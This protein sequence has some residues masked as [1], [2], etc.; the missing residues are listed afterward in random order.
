[1]DN[2]IFV[3]CNPFVAHQRFLMIFSSCQMKF[4]AV[5]SGDLRAICE[6]GLL[7]VTITI[8]E[9]EVHSFSVVISLVSGDLLLF[10]DSYWLLLKFAPSIDN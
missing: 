7:L 3:H 5:T 8:P 10:I 6:K 4:G 2:S 9:M 1:M